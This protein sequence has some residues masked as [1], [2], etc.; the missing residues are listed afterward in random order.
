[1]NCHNGHV[2]SGISFTFWCIFSFS[3]SK[4]IEFVV[5]TLYFCFVSVWIWLLFDIHGCFFSRWSYFSFCMSE[6]RSCLDQRGEAYLLFEQRARVHHW[7][8]VHSWLSVLFLPEL[9]ICCKERFSHSQNWEQADAS[10]H[11][12]GLAV[13]TKSTWPSP[14]INKL[15]NTQV[16][17]ALLWF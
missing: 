6:M 12:L 5:S 1:M 9:S 14:K 10:L 7:E 11:N 8:C 17:I 15:V 3:L 4:N 13:A 2:P 16:S